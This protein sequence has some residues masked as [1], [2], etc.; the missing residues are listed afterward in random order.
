[1]NK[2]WLLKS[3]KNITGPYSLEELEKMVEQRQISIGRDEVSKS[4]K[5]WVFATNVEELKLAMSRRKKESLIDHTS[6]FQ[7]FI[8]KKIKKMNT[9][10][11]SE[12]DSEKDLLKLDQ[13][14]HQPELKLDF[15]PEE[16]AASSD[17]DY[18]EIE[19]P[20][21][22]PT[23]YKN[24]FIN[25]LDLQEARV[26][27]YKE[28]QTA[29]HKQSLKQSSKGS[30]IGEIGDIRKQ[31]HSRVRVISSWFWLI[32]VVGALIG[33]AGYFLYIGSDTSEEE[34]ALLN[35]ESLFL[36]NARQAFK[37]GDYQVALNLFKGSASD[38]SVDIL[39]YASLVL[40]LT[41]DTHQ[42]KSL[43]GQL[44]TKTDFNKDRK[45]IIE[46]ILLLK[47]QNTP[48][49][50]TQFKQDLEKMRV[51]VLALI[52]L[53]YIQARSNNLTL[54][55]QYLNT[56]TGKWRHT[57]PLVLFLQALSQ[58]NSSK[59]ILKSLTGEQQLYAQEASL[60]SLF[61]ESKKSVS[62][63]QV[64]QVL[65]QDPFMTFDHRYDILSYSPVQI[66]QD[67][68]QDKCES[69]YSK[70]KEQSYIIA[71]YSLCL[72]QSGSILA[73]SQSIDTALAQ[74]PRDPLVLSIYAYIV[75]KSDLEFGEPY[76]ERAIK[77][78]TKYTL[79]F[80]LKARLCEYQED[81]LCADEYWRKVK[82]L[83]RSSLAAQAWEVK[84]L[85]QEDSLEEARLLFQKY[86]RVAPDYKP[87]LNL[88]QD[89]Q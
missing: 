72:A 41:H 13:Q 60:L 26:L 31:V 50:L 37:K 17:G 28:M 65:D 1:M 59:N 39:N 40:Q 8:S 64:K 70:S 57:E 21:I 79:P 9:L 51:P 69:I 38:Q 46:A 86:I 15:N 54:A 16:E 71:L 89:T 63:D 36:K 85:L 53:A 42:V 5:R 84:S 49:A 4:L 58:K 45:L 44:Q 6:T 12:K 52:H 30:D 61:L 23:S 82:H 62:I 76:I 73:A 80:I 24:V 88:A 74:A 27:P 55:N 7:T 47:E 56:I 35:P 34:L 25:P 2:I 43:I 48:G 32:C 14:N 87:L 68:L 75:S 29:Q 22:Q 20:Q 66:W 83:R 10:R 67:F 11:F 19:S 18:E 77:Y 33:S 81:W 3:K 78:N